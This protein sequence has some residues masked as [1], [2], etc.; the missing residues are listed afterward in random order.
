MKKTLSRALSLVPVL[1]CLGAIVVVGQANVTVGDPNQ[2]LSGKNMGRPA[3][4]VGTVVYDTGAPDFISVL[5]SDKIVGNRFDTNQGNPLLGGSVYQF[6]FWAS[7]NHYPGGQLL[8]V[9]PAAGTGAP[10]GS[11]FASGAV[12]G[13][14]FNAFSFS[15]IAIPATFL[16]DVFIDGGWGN[17]GIDSDTT[18]GQ[19]YHA[20]YG[21]ILINGVYS[22]VGYAA[23]NANTL[24]R[25][26]GDFVPVEL[27]QFE[28]D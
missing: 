17:V 27:M 5:T 8:F 23:Q 6:T 21:Q 18:Q 3:Q 14:N 25:M 1:C 2:D 12:A 9:H 16:A 10:L 7:G 4:V 19:G 11:V 22:I 24:L 13:S 28:I 26:T 20:F 15:P